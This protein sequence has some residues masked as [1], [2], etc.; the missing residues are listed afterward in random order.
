MSGESRSSGPVGM[1]G[2][3]K[4]YVLAEADVLDGT[5]GFEVLEVGEESVRGRVPVTDRIKQVHGLVHGGAYA[6]LAEMLAS[7]ATVRAV[8]EDGS[9]AFGTAHEVKFLR[10]ITEGT[11]HAEGR[12]IH[13]SRQMWVWDV[14]MTD[15][16]GRLCASSRVTIAVR[17]R[18]D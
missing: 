2:R 15:D 8:W 7:E 11:V 13:R 4:G 3:S 6:A 18:R 12:R 10:Q 9:I 17:S 16:H 1:P 14:D 5:L